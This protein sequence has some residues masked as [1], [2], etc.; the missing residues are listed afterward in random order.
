MVVEL[1]KQSIDSHLVG[2]RHTPNGWRTR[3]C[4][5]CIH[6]G[7]RPDTRGRFGIIYEGDNIGIHCFNCGYSTKWQPGWTLSKDLVKLLEVIGVPQSDID[8]LK[9]EAYREKHSIQPRG[10]ATLTGNITTKWTAKEFL[11]DCYTLEQWIQAGCD[12]KDFTQV[13]NYVASRNLLNEHTAQQFY[14]TPTKEYFYNKRLIIPY[15]YRGQIVG[16]TGRYTSENRDKSV[17]KYYGERPPSFIY[18]LD[19]QQDFDRKYTIIC[20]G[21]IDAIITDGVALL[22]DDINEHQIAI[23][24]QLPTTK[25]LCPDRDKAGNHLVEL[26]A[27][28]KWQ[29]AFPNWGRSLRGGP[30]KDAGEA[31]ERYG[32]LLTVQ[33]ILHSAVSDKFTIE[34]NRQRDRMNYGY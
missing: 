21:V 4:P 26:A 15:T 8:R 29:V 25:I 24:N 1:L 33:S 12:D 5:M 23:L 6:R 17:P 14:W 22:H 16:W 2:L 9:F 18:N 3:N 13:L 19:A 7:E 32:T 30:M 27:K 10:K 31:Y 28:L 11:P 34:F 20:E